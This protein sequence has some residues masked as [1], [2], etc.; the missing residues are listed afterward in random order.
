MPK[1]QALT[2]MPGAPTRSELAE[3]YTALTA[4]S[5]DALGF[6]IALAFFKLAAIVEGAYARY[7]H[8]L[9]D[10]PWARSLGADVP[11]LLEDAAAVALGK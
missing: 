10:S 1:V 6:Y 7:V 11:R 5:T 2:R 3:H 9:D 8:G 4:R